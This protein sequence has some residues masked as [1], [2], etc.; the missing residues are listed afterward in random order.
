LTLQETGPALRGV[1]TLSAASGIP[2]HTA[3]GAHFAHRN[4]FQVVAFVVTVGTLLLQGATLPLII[5]R[6]RPAFER[7]R[8]GDQAETVVAE[9]LLD[10][11][12]EQVLDL[13]E[14]DPAPEVDAGTLMEIRHA[15]ARRA[16]AAGDDLAGADA[17][18]EP[19]DVV[20]S[21]YQTVLTAQRRALV[22]QRDAGILHDETV[23]EMLDS[24]DL[25]EAGFTARLQRRL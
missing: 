5:R 10:E 18:S 25:Q 6:V 11:T 20:A 23:R 2:F 4:T 16:R 24:L 22:A 15:V 7:D 21:V 1:V 13:V 12:A 9:R 8:V 17:W 19:A 3:T 14:L